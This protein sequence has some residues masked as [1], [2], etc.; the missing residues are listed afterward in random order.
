M[1][2]LYPSD[3]GSIGVSNMAELQRYNVNLESFEQLKTNLYDSNAY[4]AAGVTTLQFFQIPI[5]QGNKTLEDTNMRLAGQLPTNQLFLV[6][7]VEV[8]FLPTDP[9]VAADM[10]AAFGAG[11]VA[12]IINDAYIFYRSGFLKFRVGSKDYIEEGPLMKF[13]PSQNFKVEGALADAT[14]AAANQQ[15]RI[16]YGY[17]GGVPYGIIPILLIE[18]QNFDITLEWPSG[19]QAIT[20]PARVVVTLDGVLFRRAQ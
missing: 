10:P 4:P 7:G 15:S 11:A 18:N 19:V 1:V 14:T 17:A 20:N 13:P 5:G 6:E 2:A 8:L 16:A 9:T 12:A 3:L